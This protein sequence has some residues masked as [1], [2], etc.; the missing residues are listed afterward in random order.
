MAYFYRAS[1]FLALLLAVTGAQP[2]LAQQPIA[3]TSEVKVV[4]IVRDENGVSQTRLEAP[5]TVVPGDRLVFRTSYSN[6]GT[7]AVERFVLTNPL[8]AAVRLAPDADAS[9]VVSVDGGQTWGEL[10]ELMVA[11]PDGALRAATADDVTHIR[12][13]L[14]VVQPGESGTLEYPA[15]IR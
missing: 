5:D 7:E 2:V 6:S 8:H 13:T 15:I 14:A 11:G 9:L 3:L 12:W 1:A 4:R 10:S